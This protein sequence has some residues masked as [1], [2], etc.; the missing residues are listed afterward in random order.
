MTYTFDMKIC[1]NEVDGNYERF[2]VSSLKQIAKLVAGKRGTFNGKQAAKVLSAYV[3]SDNTQTTKAG[4]TY[5]W[6]R[7]RVNIELNDETSALIYEIEHGSK[8]PV[9]VGRSVE[10]MVCSICGA[11]FCNHVPGDVYGG[12]LCYKELYGVNEI[13]EW[14]LMESAERKEQEN[15]DNRPRIC[16]V[17]GVGV[18]ERFTY[19]GMLGEFY[20]TKTGKLKNVR[21]DGDDLMICV[22]TLI[23]NPD[24]IMKVPKWTPQ[25]IEDAKAIQRM[26]GKE[27]FT[28]V[29]KDEDGWPS[30]MD[31][32]GKDPN[33]GWCSIGMEK[34]MFPSLKPGETVMLD[35]IKQFW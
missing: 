13:Y 30:I 17:L 23:N 2:P 21:P 7:A 34:D 3:V 22:P 4:D 5:L 27:N 18:E 35:E 24:L 12:Q 15:Q 25:E 11:E 1:D 10:H 26:F 19:P 29:Q 9:L 33:V 6:V 14:M 16:D 20:V 31:G 32:D 8:N 28:H